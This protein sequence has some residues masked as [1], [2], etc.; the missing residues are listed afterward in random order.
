MIATDHAPHS[1][2]EKSKGFEKMKEIVQKLQQRGEHIATMESCTG[3]YLASPAKET[4]PVTNS[5]W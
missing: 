1:E 3:G 2:E 5:P 4:S